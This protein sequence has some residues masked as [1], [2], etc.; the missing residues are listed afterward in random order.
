ML[1]ILRHILFLLPISFLACSASAQQG[2]QMIQPE[3]IEEAR[4]LLALDM[5]VIT[6]VIGEYY[7]VRRDGTYGA[8]ELASARRD[9]SWWEEGKESNIYIRDKVLEKGF[10]LYTRPA[11]DEVRG[12]IVQV[13]P[14]TRNL[15]SEILCLKR[16][17]IDGKIYEYWV[18]KAWGESSPLREIYFLVTEAGALEAPRKILTASNAYFR[19]F[20]VNENYTMIFPE[21]DLNV[22]YRLVAWNYPEAFAD[23]DLKDKQVILTVERELLIRPYEP[24]RLPERTRIMSP[25]EVKEYFGVP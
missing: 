24:R 22:L 10:S 13:N 19:E 14:R 17:E 16:E 25:E 15:I 2:G 12:A 4:G 23:G 21:T 9:V 20:S 11:I 5:Y 1:R 8:A 6:D 3:L 18:V 7:A